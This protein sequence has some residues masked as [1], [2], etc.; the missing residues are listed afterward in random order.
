MVDGSVT[1]PDALENIDVLVR[2]G[3]PLIMGQ[4]VTVLMLV[5]VVT[6]GDDV[7]GETSRAE[8]VEGRQLARGQ[9]RCNK[10]GPMGKHQAEP[11]GRPGRGSSHEETVGAIAEIADENAVKTGIF[12]CL[13][14]TTDIVTVD[15]WSLRWVNLRR[16][17][18][19]D[20]ADEFNAHQVVSL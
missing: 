12:M 2:A 11:F 19:S 18:S 20:H 17:L 1:S 15:R 5:V 8:M 4:I 13:S 3:I 16:S 6:T 7:D 14:E 9:R 10:P